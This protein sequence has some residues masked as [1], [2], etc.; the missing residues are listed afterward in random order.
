MQVNQV[1]FLGNFLRFKSI[2]NDTEVKEPSL[3][4]QGGGL[5]VVEI[6][7]SKSEKFDDVFKELT[8]NVP[9]R[10]T[11]IEEKEKA[12]SYIDRMLK[13]N[14]ITPEMKN[15]WTNKKNV[16]EMEIQSIKN[17]Q[18]VGKNEKWQ[19]VAKEFSD[20]TDK[21]WVENVL[22][23]KGGLD[24]LGF[25]DAQEYYNTVRRTMITFCDRIL[26]CSDL[27]DNMKEYYL[28]LKNGF[29]CDLN[30]YA[31]QQNEYNKT[32]NQ[33]TE[34]FNDVFAEMKNNVPDST[35]TVNT[36]Q[37]ALSY[38]E[39]MLSCDDIPNAE[40][41][42]NKKEVIE[43][44]IQNIKNEENLNKGGETVQDVWKEFS[45]FTNKH[46]KLNSNLSFE[47]QFENRMTYYATYKTFCLR[48]LACEGLTEEQRSEYYR[49]MQ[50]AERDIANWE[51]DYNN[52]MNDK[53]N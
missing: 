11:T 40:Y 16:I 20:F 41:W 45:D 3:L 19:D 7:A 50:N 26:A 48:F 18:Q 47:D 36:K 35:S 38:I 51:R 37:L 30:Y 31:A 4:T 24:N 44:E 15:Y 13:C 23:D 53:N 25:N 22:N 9:D 1:G 2:N 42:Q 10:T 12:L 33:K 29:K 28:N 8:Q 21:Y 32:Q 27:P 49:M 5:D 14:D 6:S 52:Y 39:R 43:M 46:F 34:S 17:E